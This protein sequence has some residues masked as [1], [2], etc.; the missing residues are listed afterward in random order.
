MIL[1]SRPRMAPMKKEK[2]AIVGGRGGIGVHTR[3]LSSIGDGVLFINHDFFGMQIS[4]VLVPT[5]RCGFRDERQLEREWSSQER[6]PASSGRFSE[7][8]CPWVR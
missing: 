4:Y 5:G 6:G 3:Y 1:V 2:R 8:G 7:T